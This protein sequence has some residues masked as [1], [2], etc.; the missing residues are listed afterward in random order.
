MAGNEQG[1][2]AGMNNAYVSIGNIIGPTLAGALF[3]V[4]LFA[5]FLCRGLH[6]F[7]RFSNVAETSIG[8]IVKSIDQVK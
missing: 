1:F 4:N 2:V 6:T 7:C 8:L 5:P 3:D